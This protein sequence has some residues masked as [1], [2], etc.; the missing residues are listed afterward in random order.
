[1]SGGVRVSWDAPAVSSP[2]VSHYVV[3]DGQCS[4][5]VRVPASATSAVMPVVAGQK[6]V[7]PQVQAVNALRYRADAVDVLVEA[8]RADT[9]KNGVVRLP[10]ADGR[11]TKIS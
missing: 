11:I 9:E 1:M 2:P 6:R 5:P 4:C 7:R 8:V 10:V 3:H